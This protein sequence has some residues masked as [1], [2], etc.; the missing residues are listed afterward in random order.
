[1]YEFPDDV[2]SVIRAY[3]KPVF[4]WFRE[5]KEAQVLTLCTR[6]M[7]KLKEAMDNPIVRE[8]LKI[9]VDAYAD[10]SHIYDIYLQE[11]TQI[12]E[13]L[14]SEADWW[15]SESLNKLVALL[16]DEMEDEWMDDSTFTS[17]SDSHSSYY[18]QLDAWHNIEELEEIYPEIGL[19]FE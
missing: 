5:Y 4:A 2:L 19:L 9:C 16:D 14:E 15:K 13:E 18:L 8:Q 12:H 7:E 17:D 11:R 10:H 6:H 1:M 3:S